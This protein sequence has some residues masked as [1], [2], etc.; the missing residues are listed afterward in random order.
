MPE[1]SA[2]AQLTIDTVKVEK[3][4]RE[5]L[6]AQNLTI[7]PQNLFGDAV[8]QFVDKDDKHAMDLFVNENLGKQIQNLVKDGTTVDEEEILDRFGQHR[9]HL[10][11]LFNAGHLK[12]SNKARL[13]PK[14]D[15]WDSDLDGSWEEQPG[16]FVLSEGDRDD[17][18]D[19]NGEDGSV[20]PRANGAARGRGKANGAASRKAATLSQRAT[21]KGRGE[22]AKAGARANKKVV[23][24]DEDDD[25]DSIM[26]D[27]D[28]IDDEAA[29]T[30]QKAIKSTARATAKRAASPLKKA[31]ARTTKASQATGKQGKLNFSQPVSQARQMNKRSQA[32]PVELVSLNVYPMVKRFN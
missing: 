17:D 29:P 20:P 16:A 22:T 18:D 32:R 9:S 24:D 25:D 1:E 11:E 3:L 7:L 19:E 8:S 4:V 31:P 15:H 5:Y 6:I 13:K 21:P 2:I 12:N 27:D 30:T 10:E 23:V 26:I 14:P 28:D